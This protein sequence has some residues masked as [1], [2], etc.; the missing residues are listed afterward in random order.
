MTYHGPE[1]LG[2]SRM[3]RPGNAFQVAIIPVQLH[4]GGRQLL[5]SRHGDRPP[6]V[7]R[8]LESGHALPVV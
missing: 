1:F 3:D 6:E 2:V 4:L 5:G 7:G 8:P